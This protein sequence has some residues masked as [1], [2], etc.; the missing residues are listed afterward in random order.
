MDFAELKVAARS[1]AL[2]PEA[3]RQI[4]SGWASPDFSDTRLG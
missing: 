4:G 2:A 1:E 3:G